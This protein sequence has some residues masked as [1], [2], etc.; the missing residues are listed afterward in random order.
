MSPALIVAALRESSSSPL[1]EPC[2]DLR[3]DALASTSTARAPAALL[4]PGLEGI[5]RFGFALRSRPSTSS[6]SPAWPVRKAWC[7]MIAPSSTDQSVGGGRAGEHAHRPPS[8]TGSV[9][10]NERVSGTSCQISAIAI[11]LARNAR[12]TAPKRTGFGALE[13]VDRLLLVADG[14]QRA[15][16]VACALAGEELLGQALDDRPLRGVGV[17]RLVDQD[18]VDTAVDL[19]QHPGRGAGAREQVLRLDD[20]VVIVERGLGSLSPLILRLDGVGEQEHRCARLGHAQMRELV[21]ERGE[22]GLRADKARRDGRAPSWRNPC[23]KSGLRGFPSAVR[24]HLPQRRSRGALPRS[25]LP[26]ED[27]LQPPVSVPA[28]EPKRREGRDGGIDLVI[29]QHVGKLREQRRFARLR[30]HRTD[31]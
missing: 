8:S 3:R 20:E 30:P 13:A 6:T 27:W 10:R 17:L 22:G 31:A 9:E 18:V 19:V 2:L 23:C 11:A 28:V 1:V 24:K 25:L 21:V 12:P 29:A 15:E 14:E 7:V 4:V 26:R 5:G 16:F